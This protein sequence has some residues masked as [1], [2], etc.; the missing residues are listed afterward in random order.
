MLGL[1]AR[2]KHPER[3]QKTQIDFFLVKKSKIITAKL[4]LM[5]KAS[6]EKLSLL[7]VHRSEL[8]ESIVELLADIA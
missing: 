7:P 4:N 5:P 2:Q 3:R 6:L 1:C 8:F